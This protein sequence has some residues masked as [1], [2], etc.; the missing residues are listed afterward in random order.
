MSQKRKRQLSL[1][2]FV[3]PYGTHGLAWR[4]PHIKAGGNPSFETWASI[5]KT[6]ERGKFDYAFFADFVGQGGPNLRGYGGW[7]QGNYFEPTALVA[8]L[9]GVTRHIGLVATINTNFNEPYNVARRLA[10]LDHLSGGRVGWNIVSS[11]AEGAAQTFGVNDGLDHDQRYVRA[12]EFVDLTKQLWDSWDDGAFDHPNKETGRFIDPASAHP[13][14]HRGK[15]FQADAL[16]DIP[17]PIQGY[18]VFFQAGNSDTGKDFAAQYAE[19]IYAAAQTLEEAQS[20]YRD[21]KGRLPKFG[22]EPDDLKVT[23]GLFFHIGR[24]RQ[25]AQEKYESFRDSVDV[26]IGRFFF[27]SEILTHPLD[28]PVPPNLPEPANG[29]GRWHQAMALARRENLTIRELVLRFA[30]VQ[31]HR[32]VVGTPVDIA[33]Q[34]ED[35]FVHE[36]ADGFNLKPSFIPESLDEFVDLV[37]PELQ[38]RGIFRKEYEGRTLREHLGLKRP[39]NPYSTRAG[40]AEGKGG[41]GVRG[42]ATQ[43]AAAT[44]S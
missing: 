20:F 4:R 23:P 31:G 17:R 7:P 30:A 5:V 12:A 22:R 6:L 13:V 41:A 1:S 43:S 33:D 2:V 19:A 36:A 34:L 21:V 3:Q 37:V 11:L 40:T 8:A 24:S 25:E 29:K 26:S 10:S 28:G 38:K 18:P 39:A 44:Q 27:G 14:H 15:Y 35:W 42:A 16:L 32:I 9:A